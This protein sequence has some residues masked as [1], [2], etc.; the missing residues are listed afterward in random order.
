MLQVYTQH[1]RRLQMTAY[2]RKLGY[3]YL[4]VR[5][6]ALTLSWLS[7]RDLQCLAGGINR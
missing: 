1:S 2:E 6:M 3:R 4:S 5:Q 7:F